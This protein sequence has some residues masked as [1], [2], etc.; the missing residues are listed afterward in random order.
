MKPINNCD[1][2]YSARKFFGVPDGAY[3][4]S[5]KKLHAELEYDYSNIRMEH[6]LG[7][8]EEGA[9]KYY[10]KFKENDDSLIGQPIKKMSKLT[11]SLMKNIDYDKVAEI[12]F[13]NFNYLHSKLKDA[14]EIIIDTVSITVPMVYPYLVKNGSEIK[15]KLISNKIFVAT[16]W[17]NVREWDND[18]ESYENYL[19]ANL[20]AIPIDQRYCLDEMEKILE[21]IC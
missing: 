12:R 1:T 14:N 9:E 2:F 15:K 16:F 11:Q 20:L 6:L 19:A 17:P 18:K 3:L 13:N 10:P 4:F 5:E 8:I 7:R 21:L